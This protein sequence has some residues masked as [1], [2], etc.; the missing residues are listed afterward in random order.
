MTA[1]F[2]VDGKF[3]GPGWLIEGGARWNWGGR[4]GV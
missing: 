3:S 4:D 1:N 2:I